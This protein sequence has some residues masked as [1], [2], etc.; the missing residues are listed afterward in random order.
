MAYAQPYEVTKYLA[1]EL[2]QTISADP[3][4]VRDEALS[5]HN[6]LSRKIATVQ[7]NL[8]LLI[9]EQAEM[10][11]LHDSACIAIRLEQEAS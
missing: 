10:K 6:V 1:H 2:R 8:A 9:G 5:R 3:W 7:R 4:A 11:A